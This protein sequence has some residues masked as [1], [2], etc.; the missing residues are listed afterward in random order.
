[1]RCRRGTGLYCRLKASCLLFK[2]RG[3]GL[4]V[5]RVIPF[6]E[7]FVVGVA[8]S[9]VIWMDGELIPFERAQVHVLSHSLHYGSAAFEGIRAYKTSDGRTAIFKAREHFER[10]HQSIAIFNG[11]CNYSVDQLIKAAA[12]TIRANGF[13]ECYI[14]PLA[15]IGNETRGLKLPAE[16]QM[17]I[18]IAVWQW[19][20][21][22]G[23]E[24][25]AKGIR[26]SVASFRR[27]DPSSSMPWAKVS[28]NYLNSIMA[29]REAT[30]RGTDEAILLD[31]QGFVAEGSGENIFVV[32]KGRM[33]TPQLANVL[34]GIT[35]GV[36]F[37]LA[38]SLDIAVDERP[39]T[40]NELYASDEVFFTGTAAEVTPVSEID[41]YKVGG[42]KPGPITG[43]IAALFEKSVRG[44]LPEN[45]AWLAFV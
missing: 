14:R 28:G 15:Y 40:R 24:V 35:R 2:A 19:G 8:D 39:I 25:M 16:P 38:K 18:A 6:G 36:V 43:K 22:L 9:K 20:K 12:D 32:R 5:A 42:G 7:V 21:Y 34:A 3:F 27:P 33:A 31:H 10:F 41:G 11:R 45:K 30:L 1:M 23:P 44:D 13:D 26:A 37:D 29:R 4:A 17:Q